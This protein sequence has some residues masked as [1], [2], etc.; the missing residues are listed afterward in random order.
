[1]IHA[2]ARSNPK[3]WIF[4]PGLDN[5]TGCLSILAFSSF[6]APFSAHIFTLTPALANTLSVHLFD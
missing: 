6:A 3:R 5:L 4:T 2:A 1:S